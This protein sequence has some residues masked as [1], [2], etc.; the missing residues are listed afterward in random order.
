MTDTCL[1]WQSQGPWSGGCISSPQSAL[2]SGV[3]KHKTGGCMHGL[4][5]GTGTWVGAEFFWLQ[6]KSWRVLAVVFLLFALLVI[7]END[8]ASHFHR[9]Q[10]DFLWKSSWLAN[11][12]QNLFKEQREVKNLFPGKYARKS[13]QAFGPGT[14]S[15]S[16]HRTKEILTFWA[17]EKLELFDS[18]NFP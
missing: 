9:D 13:Q 11:T 16:K 6:I 4:W 2:P 7:K 12:H 8:R 10:Q 15:S 17:S 1:A 5:M 14:I 18:G 3:C